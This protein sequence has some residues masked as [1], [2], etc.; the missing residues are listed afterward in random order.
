MMLLNVDVACV[1]TL[2][3]LRRILEQLF[4]ETL[5]LKF[6]FSY[7]EGGKKTIANILA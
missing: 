4:N 2:V 7:R 6:W 1:W 3:K 5:F